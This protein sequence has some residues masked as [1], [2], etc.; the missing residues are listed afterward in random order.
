[1]QCNCKHRI[2][3]SL[4]TLPTAHDVHIPLHILDRTEVKNTAYPVHAYVVQ[5]YHKCIDCSTVTVVSVC[6]EGD[7]VVFYLKGPVIFKPPEIV[8]RKM[9][10][11]ARDLVNI[12]MS[13]NGFASEVVRMRVIADRNAT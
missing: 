6:K 5:T 12:L 2:I 3:K 10:D 13:F 4:L 8:Y 11:S 9:E 1:M 7:I